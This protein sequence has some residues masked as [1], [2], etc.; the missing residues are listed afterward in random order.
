MV[1]IALTR[2]S[3]TDSCFQ[4][5]NRN[6]APPFDE[7]NAIVFGDGLNSKMFPWVTCVALI[8]FG[9]L[10][11]WLSSSGRGGLQ[12][13]TVHPE[14]GP[15]W[16]A[17]LSPDGTRV[18]MMRREGVAPHEAIEIKDVRSD[19]AVA[20][21]TL[22]ARNWNLWDHQRFVGRE[23]RYCDEG[24][25]LLAFAAPDALMMIETATSSLHSGIKF[26]VL[27]LQQYDGQELASLTY[28]PLSNGVTVD[29]ST[30]TPYVVLGS[31]GDMQA[32]SIKVFDLEKGACGRRPVADLRRTIPGRRH[33]DL[34]GW[35][36]SCCRNVVGSFTWT[37]G[38]SNR[39]PSG[40]SPEHAISCRL[41]V[42]H[43]LGR[44]CG[45]QLGPDRRGYVPG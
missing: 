41:C 26:G 6:H 11:T 31:W 29:C 4:N 38:G 17:A 15:V 40:Y 1:Y 30:H 32:S 34:S 13:N 33:S 18:A 28:I 14:G 25:Y 44:I 5:R 24:K 42:A 10:V 8:V 9:A 16:S 23:L 27:P 2:E 19:K 12:V 35:F 45:K 36:T 7:R 37:A 39:R 22:P 21:F 3:E 20:S 43:R